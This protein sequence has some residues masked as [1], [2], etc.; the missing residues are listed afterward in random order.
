MKISIITMHNYPN[1]GSVLQAFATQEKLK[2]YADEVEIIDYS[3][4]NSTVGRSLKEYIKLGLHGNPAKALAALPY[5]LRKR[6]VFGGFAKRNMNLTARR[7]TKDE[8]FAEFP[9]HDGYYF[10]GSDQVWNPFFEENMPFFLNFVPESK[11]KVAFAIS[12]GTYREEQINPGEADKIIKY[13]QQYNHISVREERG[14]KLVREQLGYENAVQ[15]VDPTLAMPP[16]FWKKLAPRSKINGAYILLYKLGNEQAFEGYASEVSKRTGLPLI[17]LCSKSFH[18]QISGIGKKLM[19]PRVFQ[20][21]TLIDNAKY[22]ITDSFHGTAFSMMLNTDVIVYREEYDGGRISG[23]LRMLGHE[24]RH[25][26]NSKDFSILDNPTNFHHV[27]EILAR[28]RE[29]VNEFLRGVFAE[30]G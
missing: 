27:N 17:R 24:Q 11:K 18:Q 19:L 16:E 1:Y 9:L 14:L 12:F 26:K 4:G 13:V 3:G 5:R 30:R 29:R 8:D 23:F 25:V 20:F 7:Y 28:E 21:I 10:T 2:E 6:A 15:L 22:V